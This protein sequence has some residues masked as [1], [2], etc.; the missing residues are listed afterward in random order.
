MISCSGTWT[1]ILFRFASSWVSDEESSVI[2]QKKL[3]NL[4][5]FSLVDEFLVISND[6]LGNGLSDCVDLSNI[7]TSSDGDSNVQVLESL[8]TQKKNWLHNFNSQWGWL[9]QFNWWS[10]NSQYS[11]SVSD[12]SVGNGVFLSSKTLDELVLWLWHC[13]GE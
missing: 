9:Q 6:T 2:L 11:L 1:T 10:V 4:S 5:L 13:Y 12:W 7:T 8:Q 3:F